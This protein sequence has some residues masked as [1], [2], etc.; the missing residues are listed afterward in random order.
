MTG[1]EAVRARHSVRNY[2]DR[3][4]DENTVRQL[5]EA[6]A[7]CNRTGRLHLQLLTDPGKTFGHMLSRLM[8]LASAPAVIAC[9]GP[10]DEG[11][12]ERIGYYG[13][14]IVLLAQALGLNTCWAGTFSK[15]Q[16]PAELAAGERLSI[17]IAVGYGKTG[18]NARRSKTAEQSAPGAADAP[19]WFREGVELALLAPTA[20]NQQN[21]RFSL[22]PD[23]TVRAADLGG[24][25]SRVDLG[26]VKY[27]FDLAR[28]AA[29]LPDRFFPA[30]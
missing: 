4:I 11:L 21:F 17:V 20:I 12:D 7:A 28:E 13:E 29:G 3:K 6:I 2:L 14:R 5:Q 8:G 16:V 30:V 9:A 18:G 1:I 26:I 22:D 15:G 23:G 24:P 25:F 10:D 19:Q 27:H